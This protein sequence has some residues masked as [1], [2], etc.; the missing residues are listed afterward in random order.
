MNSNGSIVNKQYIESIKE[1]PGEICWSAFV[2]YMAQFFEIKDFSDNEIH[3]S[4]KNSGYR[5]L[6]YSKC[7]QYN[8]SIE[9]QKYNSDIV[10]EGWKTS[11][12][13][14]F[15]NESILKK[16]AK[17]RIKQQNI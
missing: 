10:S 1:E 17:E 4:F 9:L 8:N 13:G 5:K 6:F 16:L 2:W 3:I 11:H 14:K 7:R 12:Q 15:I